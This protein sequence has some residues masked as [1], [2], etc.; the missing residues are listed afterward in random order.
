[1]L[2]KLSLILLG[3]MMVLPI[4]SLYARGAVTCE[5]LFRDEITMDIAN[6][7]ES[8]VDAIKTHPILP[9]EFLGET[10]KAIEIKRKA[11]ELSLLNREA[12]RQ[13]DLLTRKPGVLTSETEPVLEDY[14]PTDSFYQI[15]DGISQSRD[16][17]LEASGQ[18]ATLAKEGAHNLKERIHSEINQIKRKIRETENLA[19]KLDMLV[20]LVIKNLSQNKRYERNV[21]L[22]ASLLTR[23]ILR[24]KSHKANLDIAEAFERDLISVVKTQVLEPSEINNKFYTTQKPQ[25]KEAQPLTGN[26]K[27]TSEQEARRAIEIKAKEGLPMTQTNVQFPVQASRQFRHSVG[28]VIRDSALAK[29]LTPEQL[30]AK[31]VQI[32]KEEDKKAQE[33]AR[34]RKGEG[35]KPAIQAAPEYRQMIGTTA[36]IPSARKT[37]Y[38]NPENKGRGVM[39]GSYIPK[40]GIDRKVNLDS[41]ARHMTLT[42]NSKTSPAVTAQRLRTWIV[43]ND[44]R[45]QIIVTLN[46]DSSISVAEKI[47]GSPERKAKKLQEFKDEF[48]SENLDLIPNANPPVRV[49]PAPPKPVAPP[50]PATLLEKVSDL[51]NYNPRQHHSNYR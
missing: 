36:G 34:I 10:F 20:P 23:S 42:M 43:D 21:N 38:T 18:D 19:Y 11:S 30:E 35:L 9:N 45:G 3:T 12:I 51:I 15:A 22:Y 33:L 29:K 6:L 50:K 37:E 41:S 8:D 32:K 5:S 27:L 4:Q 2:Q 7:D 39:S 25:A 1:M 31:R 48:S 46:P 28:D 24:I 40:S 44:L 13:F 16:A 26:K 47:N 14:S 17:F 49:Q